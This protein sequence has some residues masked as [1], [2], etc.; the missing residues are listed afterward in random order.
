MGSIQSGVPMKIVRLTY[1]NSVPTARLLENR[2]ITKLMRHPLLRSV[3][4]LSGLFYEFVVVTES[5]A[6]RAFYHEINERLLTY[7]PQR[8]IPN[9]LF[10]N[11]QNKQTVHEIVKPLREMGIPSAAIVDIDVIK[12]GGKNWA[13]LMNGAF[14]PEVTKQETERSRSSLKT[15][16]DEKGIDFKRAGG[17]EVLDQ[18]DREACNYLFD[19]LGEY[20]VFVIRKGELESWL[21]SLG[22]KGHGPSWLIDVF[23]K[24]GDDPNSETYIRPTDDDVW[25]FIE[26]VRN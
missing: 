3:N 9:C 16:F 19:R 23:E 2:K 17:I 21:F 5:D 14:I 8:G 11:A 1:S 7:S 12:E 22:A 13:N 18:P 26:S 20:G 25:S 4:A 10:L 24:M 6:D 15:K